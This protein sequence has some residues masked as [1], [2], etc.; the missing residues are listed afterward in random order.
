MINRY[1]PWMD[2]NVVVPEGP[3]QCTVFFEYWLDAALCS[4]AAL[5]AESLASSD[6][7]LP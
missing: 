7:V 5:I 2:T 4:D 1:G 3:E 6:L